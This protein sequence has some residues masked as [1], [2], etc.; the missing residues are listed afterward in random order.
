MVTDL[1]GIKQNSCLAAS[2]GGGVAP[3]TG[4]EEA[5]FNTQILREIHRVLYNAVST[6][7]DQESSNT[8]LQS[9]YVHH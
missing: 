4:N 1:I 3:S 9:E 6:M 2:S 7:N 5:K 8:Q